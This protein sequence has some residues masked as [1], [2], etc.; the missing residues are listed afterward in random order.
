M[1]LFCDNIFSIKKSEGID[2]KTTISHE[3]YGTIEFEESA[4]SSKKKITINGVP[5]TNLGKKA[6]VSANGDKYYI[7]GNLLKGTTLIIGSDH[8]KLTEPVKWYEIVLSVLPFI[9][10]MVWGN[11]VQLCEIVPVV[12]GAIG[13]A[14]SAL[15]GI[16]NLFIIRSVKP[17]WLKVII[18]IAFLGA[19]YLI[20]FLIGYAILSAVQSLI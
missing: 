9:L 16:V 14:I 10:I 15:M 12:G 2:T 11:S 6:F 18:S 8:I 13:G 20:C 4:W 3:T 1:K 7:S 19:T 5:L 17:V